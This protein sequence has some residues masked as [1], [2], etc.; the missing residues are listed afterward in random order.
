MPVILGGIVPVP[1]DVKGCEYNET[2]ENGKK[3]IAASDANVYYA[4]VSDLGSN[5][6]EYLRSDNVHF[7]ATGAGKIA[8]AVWDIITTND[9]MTGITLAGTDSPAENPLKE[10]VVN[11][12][13]VWTFSTP[14]ALVEHQDL[15]GLYNHRGT[16]NKKD[17]KDVALYDGTPIDGT[18]AATTNAADRGSSVTQGLT[19]AYTGLTYIYNVNVGLAGTFMAVIKPLGIKDANKPQYARLMLNGEE[20]QA[21]KIES[22]SD[23]V[24]LVGK[25]VGSGTFTVTCG[26]TWD[27]IGAKYIAGDSNIEIMTPPAIEAGSEVNTIKI[28]PGTS[29]VA[30]VEV[31]TYYTTDDTSPTAE[32]TLYAGGDIK[33]TED[34]VVRAVS[35]SSNGGKAYSAVYFF[36][37]AIEGQTIQP[38]TKFQTFLAEKA[39]DFTGLANV[40][41]YI[42][43]TPND[44]YVD[45]GSEPKD[46]GA[47]LAPPVKRAQ[48]D[49]AETTSAL[50]LVRV[51]KVPA[52]SAVLVKYSDMTAGAITV[53]YMVETITSISTATGTMSVGENLLKRATQEVTSGS[54]KI[55]AVNDTGERFCFDETESVSAGA[56]YLELSATAIG[57]NT[58]SIAINEDTDIPYLVESDSYLKSETAVYDFAS[59]CASEDVELT[60]AKAG[61]LNYLNKNGAASGPSDFSFIAN[62]EFGINKLSLRGASD[63][64]L[65]QL[66][67]GLKT[68]KDDRQLAIHQ[69]KKGDVIGI[70]YEGGTLKYATVADKGDAATVLGSALSGLAPIASKAKVV[71][72]KILED[73]NYM[74]FYPST[75]CVIKQIFINPSDDMLPDDTDPETEPDPTAITVANAKV[76]LSDD[77]R[78]DRKVYEAVFGKDQ[79]FFYM[80]P[81]QD[82]T[83]RS[84]SYRDSYEESPFTVTVSYNGD[85]IYWTEEIRDGV[86]YESKHDTITVNTIAK[87]PAVSFVNVEDSV[88]IYRITWSKGTTLHYTLGDGAEETVADKDTVDV[89]VLKTAMLQAYSKNDYVTSDT[90]SSRAYAPTPA[91]AVDS[92]Y[93]FTLLKDSFGADYTLT[94]LGYD[95]TVVVG[96]VSLNRPNGLTAK[97]LDIFAFTS[98]STDSKGNTVESTDWRLLNAGRLRAAKS[99]NDK[100][101]AI[102]GLKK[103]QRLMLTYSGGAVIKYDALGTA[104]LAEGTDTLF[105]KQTY[106]ITTNGD[107]LLTIPASDSNCDITVINLKAPKDIIEDDVNV[108]NATV[109][110]SDDSRK[111][112]KVYEAVF[113]KDQKFFYMRPGQD[114]TARSQSYR[115]SYEESPFTVTVS[116]NG[117]FIYWTEE[118]RDGVAYESKHDTITVNTIAKKPAVSFVNVEDSVSIYRIT[119]SKGTTLHY[120]LGD[121]AEETVADKDTVDV[122]VLKT[123][124]LQAYSKNDYVTSDTLSTRVYAPTP[125]IAADGLYD[126][127]QL[128]DSIGADYTL[129]SMGYDGTAEVGGMT[130]NNPN[131]LTSK[132]L[133][134]FAFSA[135]TTDSKGNTIEST[136]W[137]LLNAGRLRAARSAN[138]KYLSVMGVKQGTY[139]VLTYSGAP[140]KYVPTGTARLAEG[141]DTLLSQQAYPVLSDG[142]LLFCIPADSVSNCDITSIGL[143]STEIVG[144]PTIAL[145][146]DSVPNVIRIRAGKSSFGMPVSIRYTTDGSNPTAENGILSAKSPV[147]LTFDE[148]T[149]IKAVTM[150]ESGV[151]SAMSVYELNLPVS[152][153]VPSVVY[154]IDKMLVDGHV[155]C[156]TLPVG[157]YNKEYNSAESIW[158]T[159]L[160]TDFYP[161]AQTNGLVTARG[162]ESS[163]QLM[164]DSVRVRLTRALAVH[165]L[166]VGDEIAFVYTGDGS[167][168]SAATDE[169]DEFTVNG[170]PAPAGTRIPSGA[171]IK[172]TKT[173]Y[174][175][176]YVVVT[177][178]GEKSGRVYL[179]G[180]YINSDIPAVA[181]VPTVELLQV[182]DT[183][184]IYR[185]IYE[186]GEQLH[187]ILDVNGEELMGPTTGICDVSITKSTK[188]QAWTTREKNG[189]MS[190]SDILSTTL[191]AP[192]PAPS[193]DGDVDFAEVSEGLPSDL[194]VT[195]DMN[196][197]V[198]VEGE[199]L[200]KPSALTAATFADRFAFSETNTSG[201]IK[202]RT[203][204]KLMFA[205]GGDMSMA[206]LNLRA[207]DIV[208]FDYTGS[209]QIA[210]ADMLEQEQ[211]VAASSR[212]AEDV[213]TYIM[214]SGTAYEVRKDGDLLLK[215]LLEESNVN[216]TKM[217]VADKPHSSEATSILFATAVEEYEALEYGK[218]TS[219]YY[220]GK[221]SSQK[222]YRLTN[223]MKELPIKGKLS[224]E[225]ASGELSTNG[226]KA[227]NR[228]VAI[229]N[230]ARG[231]V[232]VMHIAEGGVT[233]EGHA[234]KGDRIRVGDHVLEPGDSLKSGDVIIVDKVDYLNNY[235]VLKLDSKAV[236]TAMF[237]NSE[238]VENVS[239]PTIVDKGKNV[240]QIT[241]GKSSIGM[242][243]T[244]CYTIDG[245]EPTELNGTSGPYD[246]FEVKLLES[247]MVTIKAITY[248]ETGRSSST[249]LLVVYADK[250][251]YGP[252]FLMDE[253]GNMYD[254]YNVYGQ[255]VN[256]VQRGQLYIVN[257]KKVIYK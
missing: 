2:V 1:S 208:A 15:N 173:K 42:V 7:N 202:I 83:A 27:F 16:V 254:V 12:T 127:S 147:D 120:T 139:L 74:V 143:L 78:K 77:S 242:D 236:I 174:S 105:S 243:V 165:Q 158:S 238:E 76:T 227:S 237:I 60:T 32:S 132:T 70:V 221:E 164:S 40:E 199:L 190:T 4:D 87:K 94:S 126:F 188:M 194:E 250:M 146:N 110:L 111:D 239:M 97:T 31:K 82:E 19:A 34:C 92:L 84:Q 226:F 234:T 214:E 145:K 72:S 180:I 93:D 212:R 196:Q 138:D 215:L 231:D 220:N 201:K 51:Y 101:L 256:A 45:V 122:K 25:T 182:V 114:E 225:G 241:A 39:L 233:Y 108:V 137:R 100:H 255:K 98:T 181:S 166:G 61:K 192:T 257:G 30:D 155:V 150:S 175:N 10:K 65:S 71:V 11:E 123:A 186:E 21:V 178:A 56:Y 222:F 75:S 171:V 167:L 64:T 46:G 3:A 73:N 124:M 206:I 104:K 162:G 149:V 131:G 197:G 29:D 244:T 85:F 125:S 205:K 157:V 154:S 163:F 99:D 135:P 216:I 141:T 24:Q 183:T 36:E 151:T 96:G 170:K 247:G 160:R 229:H 193:E 89:K 52:G 20:L 17:Y 191:F 58:V 5:Y 79:K 50:Q 95:G 189:E 9:L 217:Y 6:T 204:S 200:Y 117:D 37:K 198:T 66:D 140:V 115:D 134:I 176:N 223:D 184:A 80:R 63:W 68:L 119:W 88:S 23:Y 53:P 107:L 169:G 224:V 57:E 156:D 13:T 159:K 153:N 69:L 22:T 18:Y 118:I 168:W 252:S 81:G 152:P 43:T 207:G 148:S 211:M 195:L 33:L 136:D 106:E 218:M 55:F 144:Q 62:A 210:N 245:T 48:E 54:K 133:D 113:G 161:L 177:P 8:D 248:S 35:I 102:L 91:I 121:G 213:K 228:R 185:F 251:V 253:N 90:L 130:L 49:A 112:R 142:D 14:G 203:G 116:Y 179:Q 38:S 44:V 209:I 59:A 232:I 235:V 246:Q 26:E 28:V 128:K 41:A 47:A 187:Y 67:G 103:G 129:T 109:T 230:V 86:A 172:V 219:V 249:A 240:I